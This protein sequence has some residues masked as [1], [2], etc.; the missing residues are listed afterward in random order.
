ME[1][2]SDEHKI[3]MMLS[4][5]PLRTKANN[6]VVPTIDGYSDDNDGFTYVIMPLFTSA[7]I[8]LFETVLEIYEF[9]I[10][11]LKVCDEQPALIPRLP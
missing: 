5:N 8:R 1:T 9:G 6:P 11:V 4:S 3:F 7:A 2:Y 10:Q